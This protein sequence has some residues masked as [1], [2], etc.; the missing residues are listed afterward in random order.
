MTLLI[1]LLILSV[2]V[3]VHELGHFLMAKRAGI[4]VEE[5]G[6][7]LPPRIWGKKIGETIYSVNW[8][9][10][11]GFVKLFGEDAEPV[12]SSQLSV[13]RA[14]FNQ[15]KRVRLA[16][17]IAGVVMN[18]GLGVVLFSVIYSRLGIPTKTET[19]RVMEVLADSPAAQAGIKSGEVVV[20]VGREPIKST[21]RF[22]EVIEE[23]RGKSV[24]ITLGDGTVG[25]YGRIVT[26]VPREKP[27]E[28][29]GALGVAI[30]S[31]QMKQFPWWQMPIR[32]AV[33]GMREAGAWG[34]T[35]G[36]GLVHMVSRWVAEG[37][38][39]TDV[40]GPVGI[41]Q[42]TGGIAQAGLLAVL[43]FMGVLSINL[44]VLNLLPLP[45]LDGGRLAFLA[46]EAVTRRRIKPGV[47]KLVHA[48]GMAVLLGLMAVVT[49][50]DV[51]RLTGAGS[52]VGLV[53][54]AWPF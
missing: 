33:V 54:R 17:L 44:A 9:P 36:S 40:A 22:I 8:L 19:V 12:I 39:P 31:I 18:F 27:P 53:Q 3:L 41:F 48:A 25:K 34:V 6:F 52:F 32:G 11:G 30:S 35:I 29:E 46:V 45:A 24:E 37:R 10:I 26:V 16:V 47:E 1:F 43:Q 7:G 42:L 50:N 13:N 15:K 21:E 2:L 51:V 4:L 5:F 23:S 38:V 49:V 28:G 20:A 14:F